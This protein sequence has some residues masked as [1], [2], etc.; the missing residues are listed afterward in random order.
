MTKQE[1]FSLMPEGISRD[2]FLKTKIQ[3]DHISKPID[4]M[5]DFEDIVCKIAAIQDTITPDIS[6]RVLIVFCSDNGIVSEGVTQSEQDITRK[7]AIALGNNKSAACC[8]AKNVNARV[9]SVDIGINSKEKINGVLDKKIS[10]GTRDFLIE[11]AMKE[12]ELLKAIKTGIELAGQMKNDGVSLIATGEMGI[13][14]TTTS[15]AVLSAILGIDSDEIVGRGAGLDN[16]KLKIKRNVVKEGINKYKR[17]FEN[18]KDEKERSFEILRCLGG[19]DIAAMCGVFLGGAI[20]RIPVL[21]DGV[22]SAVAALLAEKMVRGTK[23]YMI[24]SHCGREK[25]I[26]IVLNELGLTYS[27]TGNMALGE[28][29]GALMMI[30]L[31]DNAIYLY[32]NG[33]RFSETGIEDYERFNS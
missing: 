4:G 5:G 21:I 23:D 6:N 12:D 28:G 8:L 19:L 15:A 30:P 29:T 17:I 13:G 1:L 32:E 14:N 27:I 22:I 11:P 18:A 2:I 9:L 20:Y 33:I 16:E 10:Y 24:A 3:W 7:V 31:L 26:K 25:G